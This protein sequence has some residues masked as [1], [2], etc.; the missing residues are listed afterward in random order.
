MRLPEDL[1]G[2]EIYLDANV[3]RDQLGA[4]IDSKIRESVAAARETIEHAG[5]TPHDI[6][7]IVFVGGPTQY[8]PLRDR[9][10]FELGIAAS[11]TSTL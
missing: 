4:L 10:A 8:K 2:K 9:V 1:A 11:T 5:L 3:T 6:E 7:R